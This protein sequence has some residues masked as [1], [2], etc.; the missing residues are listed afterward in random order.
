MRKWISGQKILE[1]YDMEGFELF[2]YVKKGLQ[3]YNQKGELKPRPDVSEKLSELKEQK[4]NLAILERRIKKSIDPNDIRQMILNVRQKRAGMDDEKELHDTKERIKTIEGELPQNNLYSWK[5]YSLPDP[6]KEAIKIVNDLINSLF[7]TTEFIK[8][9]KQS[10]EE[11][12]TIS[13]TK[14]N[15]SPNQKRKI[16]CQKIAK[17]IWNKNPTI[18]IADMINHPDILPY[19]MK[20]NGK[21][22][23]EKAI[24]N[25]IKKLCPN[26]SPGRRA[27]PKQ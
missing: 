21:Y 19:T 20:K 26:R 27:K 6:E 15:L 7:K 16:E 12:S 13:F 22:Y 24:R 10:E 1:R 4:K 3:P 8:L 23:T 11:P 14:N 18:T 5:D 25:W 9:K 17:K 2:G